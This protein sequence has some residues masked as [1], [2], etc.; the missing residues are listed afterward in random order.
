MRQ[1]LS[2]ACILMYF[3]LL[4]DSKVTLK[5]YV[6]F[7]SC[8][9]ITALLIQKSQAILVLA[10]LPF[11]LDKYLTRKMLGLSVIVSLIIGIFFMSK[12]SGFLGG[13]ASSI[14]DV[15]YQNY[16]MDTNSMGDASNMT[17]IAHSLYCLVLIYFLTLTKCVPDK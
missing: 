12:V 7:C 10:I 11:V 6:L 9:V 5:K 13:L 2:H 1:S 15:R 8:T 3:P 17:L 14:S 4:C 16:L